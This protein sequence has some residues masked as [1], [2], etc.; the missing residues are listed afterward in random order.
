MAEALRSIICPKLSISFQRGPVDPKFQVERVTSTHNSFSQQT[1]LNDLYG[2]F[3]L[4]LYGIYMVFYIVSIWYLYSIHFYGIKNWT[5]FSSVLSQFTRLSDKRKDGRTDR[6]T[7]TIL[8][9]RLRLHSM[10]RG[11]IN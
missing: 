4:S 10:Q 7:D 6:R 11:K 2:I 9:A 8:I 3:I 1:R 5:D